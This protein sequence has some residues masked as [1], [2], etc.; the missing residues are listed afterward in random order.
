MSD[1]G[2]LDF[3]GLVAA[4]RDLDGLRDKGKQHPNFHFKSRPFLH[5]H[6]SADGTYADVRWDG[7]FE[8][9]PAS[10]PAERAALLARVRVHVVDGRRRRT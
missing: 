4:L 7:E 10:T 3:D 5:F 2:G 6:S 8:S 1:D 9:V